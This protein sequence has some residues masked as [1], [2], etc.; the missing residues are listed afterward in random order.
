MRRQFAPRQ[1]AGMHLG[2]QGF[3]TAIEHF[4]KTGEFGHLGHRQAFVGQQ[5]GSAASG[6]EFDAKRVQGLGKFNNAGFVG[7]GNECVHG[8]LR[9]FGNWDLYL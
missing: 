7:D 1:Q 5:L 6:N 2:V 8:V 3:D 9:G 4:R